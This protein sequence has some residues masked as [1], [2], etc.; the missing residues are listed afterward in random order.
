[1]ETYCKATETVANLIGKWTSLEMYIARGTRCFVIPLSTTRKNVAHELAIAFW[2]GHALHIFPAW[3][4]SQHGHL[5]NDA[6]SPYLFTRVSHATK[7]T[8][9]IDDV[10]ARFNGVQEIS[11]PQES[12]HHFVWFHWRHT[13][14][15]QNFGITVLSGWNRFKWPEI[16]SQ[17]SDVVI[18]SWPTIF[19]IVVQRLDSLVY[20]AELQIICL[21]I[22]AKPC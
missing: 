11:F 8:R 22:Q 16:V 14:R 21:V 7:W 20:F 15:L 13:E 5:P 12:F 9:N 6:S 3:A 19:R 2:N 17:N 10:I 18:M 1:M 4:S